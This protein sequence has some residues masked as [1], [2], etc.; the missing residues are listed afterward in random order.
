M[1]HRSLHWGTAVTARHSIEH[2]ESI[3]TIATNAGQNEMEGQDDGFG[4]GGGDEYG[5]DDG[6]DS[7]DDFSMDSDD[8]FGGGDG[9]FTDGLGG[10]TSDEF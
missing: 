6:F 3:E 8:S 1:N 4:G 10:D 2:I 7:M 5:F 9:D